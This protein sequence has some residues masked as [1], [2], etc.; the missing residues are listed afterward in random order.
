[1]NSQG[2]TYYKGLLYEGTGL[3]GKSE[4][5]IYDPIDPS[6]IL[7]KQTLP[8]DFFGEGITYYKDKVGNDRIIQITWQ[9]KIAFIYDADSL[10]LIHKFQYRTS[11]GEGWGISFID[12]DCEF[13]VSDGS[14]NLMFW[15]C[16]TFEEKRNVEVKFYQNNVGKEVKLLNELEVIKLKQGYAV[17]ANVWFHNVLLQ[18]DLSD[19][20]VEKIYHF[21]NLNKAKKVGEDVFN[22]IAITE[23]DNHSILYVTG[24]LWQFMY[25]VKLNR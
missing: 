3:H 5:K 7:K 13:V 17:L 4:I 15:D 16:E 9:E 25:K 11:T 20:F 22:G 23:E 2:L 10:E 19:G 6:N 24:K 21:N 1:M 14:H 8:S 12:E 18:I